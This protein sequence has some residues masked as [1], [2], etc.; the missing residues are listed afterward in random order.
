VQDL[1]LA[2]L[3][4]YGALAFGL[5]ILIQLL[6]TGSTGVHAP[7]REAGPT[8]LAGG[9][10]LVTGIGLSAVGSRVDPAGG[11]EELVGARG[12]AAGVVLAVTGILVTFG[13]Q[14]AMGSAWRIGVDR[15]ERTPLVTGGPFTLVRNPIYAGMIPFFMGIALLVPNALTVAG[16]LVVLT[17]LEVQTRL[18]EEPHLLRTH[19]EAYQDYAAGVGRFVPGVGRLR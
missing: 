18:V 14:L 10:L 9:A 4:T 7:S 13:S 19:G 17:A 2:L 12:H 1:A 11:L 3:L 8:E 6:R 16:A 5:R 15:G